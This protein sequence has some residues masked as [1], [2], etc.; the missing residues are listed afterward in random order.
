VWKQFQY[1]KTYLDG[2]QSQSFWDA[3]YEK[4]AAIDEGLLKARN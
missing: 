3:E 4:I 1:S 2:M